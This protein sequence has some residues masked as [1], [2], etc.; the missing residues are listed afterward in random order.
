MPLPLFQALK[1]SH[2]MEKGGGTKTLLMPITK[3]ILIGNT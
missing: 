1:F 2:V 3:K